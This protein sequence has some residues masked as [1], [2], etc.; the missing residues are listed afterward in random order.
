MFVKF[1]ESRIHRR[2]NTITK[3]QCG[4]HY[5]FKAEMMQGFVDIGHAVECD[6]DGNILPAIQAALEE[7]GDVPAVPAADE[8]KRVPGRPK[9]AP[10]AM[11]NDDRAI[12]VPDVPEPERDLVK[13]GGFSEV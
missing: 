8:H 10:A 1:T 7:S 3:F 4:S 5:P 9:K 6:K 2:G 12:E 13:N 11:M